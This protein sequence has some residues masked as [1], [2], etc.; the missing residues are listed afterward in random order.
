MVSHP[1]EGPLIFPPEYRTAEA[2]LRSQLTRRQWLE[3]IGMATI[4][5]GDFQII[6][7]PDHY[8]RSYR[9]RL[10]RR[11]ICRAVTNPNPDAY[12]FRAHVCPS[13]F[14]LKGRTSHDHS[15][16]GWVCLYGHLDFNGVRMPLPGA[17]M[18]LL[19]AV[20]M[21]HVAIRE[22]CFYANVRY[23]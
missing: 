16:P 18:R 12:W 14:Y 5:Q 22:R 3:W 4:T 6:V 17:I 8:K 19:F 15:T 23:A 21:H 10:S 20:R 13:L 7:V 9:S 1:T 2:V 11:V